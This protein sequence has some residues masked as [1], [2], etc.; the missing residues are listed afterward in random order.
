MGANVLNKAKAGSTIPVKF[1]L[2][3]NQGLGILAAG[4][5]SS[6]TIVCDANA[7]VD[8]LEELAT[9]TTSGLKYDALADQY[10]YNWKTDAKSIGCRQLVVKLADGTSYRANFTFTK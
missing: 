10:I 3:G 6:G 5:P 4:S 7:I 2:N 1:R 8:P 9:T